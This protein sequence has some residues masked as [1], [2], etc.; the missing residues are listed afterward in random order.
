MAQIQSVGKVSAATVR[1]ILGIV[2]L[3]T[4]YFI[5]SGV[6]VLRH[7]SNAMPVFL[8][9]LFFGWTGV[10]WIVVL[11]WSFSSNVTR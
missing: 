9:N 1:L 5:P 8:T 2:L 7:H 11:I 3:L 6:A 4:L 10:G